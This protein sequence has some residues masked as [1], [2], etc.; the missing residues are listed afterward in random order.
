MNSMIDDDD[1]DEYTWCKNEIQTNK[2]GEKKHSNISTVFL[3]F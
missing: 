2:T 1:D 3:P